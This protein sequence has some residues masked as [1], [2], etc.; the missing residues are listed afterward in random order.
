[1]PVMK[2]NPSRSGKA[3]MHKA[4]GEFK[5]GTFHSGSKQGP[6]V[7]KRKQAVAIGLAQGRRKA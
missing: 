6:W 2:T 3:G 7:R 5:R 4:M 1:M